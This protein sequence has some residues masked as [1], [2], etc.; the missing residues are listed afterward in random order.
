MLTFDDARLDACT[1]IA[2][3]LEARGLRG[4]FFIRS[5]RIAEQGQASDIR[6][7]RDRGHVIGGHLDVKRSRILRYTLGDVIHEFSRHCSVL[8]EILGTHITAVSVPGSHYPSKL[9]S[10]AAVASI[11]TIFTSEPTL[12]ADSIEGCTLQGRFTITP[13]TSATRAAAL[14]RGAL[15]P[16]LGQS[17]FWNLKRYL[18][19]RSE[20]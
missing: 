4:Y 3:E 19:L 20:E 12:D 17:V 6:K 2:D 15:L 8:H 14:A 11:E 9:A 7:L 10:A 13:H 1:Y 16:R 18:G 5:N